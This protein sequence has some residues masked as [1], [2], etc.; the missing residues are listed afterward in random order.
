MRA[1]YIAMKAFIA[2]RKIIV[3]IIGFPIVLIGLILIPLP[4][5]GILITLLGL[6]ILSLEFEWAKRHSD[7]AKDVI[8]SILEKS[9]QKR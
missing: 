3:A 2:F 7:K 5:P 1:Y 9:K 6:I 4:G 8:K